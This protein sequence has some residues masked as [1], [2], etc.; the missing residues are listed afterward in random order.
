MSFKKIGLAMIAAL[1]LGACDQSDVTSP[2]PVEL[3]FTVTPEMLMAID[4]VTS[5][6]EHDGK[7][8]ALLNGARWDA[9]QG[10]PYIIPVGYGDNEDPA[11]EFA[12][13]AF[14]L[15]LQLGTSCHIW[16]NRPVINSWCDF[17]LDFQGPGGGGGYHT[18]LTMVEVNQQAYGSTAA[19]V[20]G[21]EIPPGALV[22]IYFSLGGQEDGG[23]Y[24]TDVRD[25]TLPGGCNT[26]PTP[27]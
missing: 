18:Q 21:G 10:T 26:G 5:V 25:G 3:G 9:L 12:I 14:Q 15:E 27:V 13:L 16:F 11:V 22:T 2:E 1:A 8:V 7:L 20:C 19:S 24:D 17:L 23:V 4:G 6:V